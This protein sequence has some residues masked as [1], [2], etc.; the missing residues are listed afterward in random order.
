MTQMNSLDYYL[1]ELKLNAVAS[2]LGSVLKR[3]DN[4]DF[5]KTLLKLLELEHQD[6]YEKA[7]NVKLRNARFPKVKTIDQYD[8]KCME[9]IDK[10]KII[11]LTNCEYIE[12]KKNVVFIGSCGTGKTHLAVSLGVCACQQ[13]KSV[14]FIK[15]GTLAN[16][17][18]EAGDEK[19]LSRLKA[20]LDKFD[21]LIL[22]EMGYIPLNKEGA[23]LLYDVISDRYERSSLIV[24]SNL[25]FAEWTQIFISH[26]MT[27]ALIDRLT[28]HSH[29]IPMNGDSYRLKQSKERSILL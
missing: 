23:E 14:Y 1:Q 12:E 3:S 27:T 22:D 15:A 11:E 9:N 10:K 2:N 29:L 13:N 8:F 6:R 26:K 16:Q 18:I 4:L 17:L 28:H 19:K 25:S 21:L 24:T 7:I 5:K 20:R